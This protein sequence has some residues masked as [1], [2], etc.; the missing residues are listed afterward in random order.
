MDSRELIDAQFDRAV[1]IVQGLPKTGPIQTGYEEKLTMYSLYKQAT[2]GNV[3]GG[4]PGM[5]DMLGR[6]KWDAWAKHK[7][8]DLFEAKWLYVDALLKVLSKYSDKTVARDLMNE[9]QS[10]GGDP[11]NLVMSHSLSRSRTSQSSSSSVSENDIPRIPGQLFS[12]TRLEAHKAALMEGSGSSSEDGESGDEAHDLPPLREPVQQPR[13]LSSMSSRYRTPVTGPLAM[14]PPL[15]GLANAPPMQPMPTYQTQ[16]AFAGQSAPIASSS[17]YP[18]PGQYSGTYQS[19]EFVPRIQSALSI[20]GGRPYGTE[21]PIRTPSRLPLEQA[22]ENVQT[23]LAALTERLDMLESQVVHPQ[24]STV[25]LPLRSSSGRGSPTD[26]R[27]EALEWDLDDM[28]MWSLVLK[29]SSRVMV[30]LKQLLIFFARSENRSPVLTIVRRLFLD[31]SFSLAVL[32]L[33]RLTWKKTT[34]RRREVNA[35]LILL[36]AAL[37]GRN[38]GRRM[39]SGV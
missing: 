4:R 2:V 12:S 8:L 32:G 10:Y 14:S 11:S 7:D 25:S 19:P 9:L 21:A 27:P 36:W 6:A 23:H 39:I 16:S 3:Q 5:W 31:I 30:S 37:S 15:A 1:E 18:P 17:V 20:R 35:A 33:L 26:N 22:V 13:P 38:R 24:R 28:G 29:P 34:T